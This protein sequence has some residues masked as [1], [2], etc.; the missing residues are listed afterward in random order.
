MPG[1]M[2]P[3]RLGGRGR[4]GA[5][6][7]SAALGP[8][9]GQGPGP[10]PS[11]L[12]EVWASASRCSSRRPPPRRPG[13]DWRRCRQAVEPDHVVSTVPRHRARHGW[14]G[15]TCPSPV[16][17]TWSDRRRAR[18]PHGSSRS[19]RVDRRSRSRARARRDPGGE[20][21]PAAGRRGEGDPREK[22]RQNGRSVRRAGT[23]PQGGRVGLPLPTGAYRVR[24]SD[25][26]PSPGSNADSGRPSEA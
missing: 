10:R 8:G 23:S 14:S 4:V 12:S 25:L 6:V 22:N 17:W 21:Q 19:S 16:E 24:R 3:G 2:A 9:E 1:R 11:A 7:R 26:G 20:P 18:L 13:D 5:W 15:V